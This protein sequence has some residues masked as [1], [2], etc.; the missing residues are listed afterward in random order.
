[1]IALLPASLLLLLGLPARA[2]EINAQRFSP[3]VDG[4]TFLVLN[5]PDVGLSGIGGGV[6]FNYAD[7]PFVFR[8]ADEELADIGLLDNIATANLTTFASL[9]NLSFGLDM[10]LHLASSGYGVD[11]FRLLGDLGLDGKLELL[12]RQTQGVGVGLRTRLGLPT[13]NGNAWLGDPHASVTG[14]VL[15]S[16]G[17]RVVLAVNAGFRGYMGRPVELPEVSWGNRALYGA[18]LSVPL[19]DNVWMT[20]ELTGE[21][22]F[23]SGTAS[24]AFP[25]EGLVTARGNPTEDLIATL[26]MGAGLT[27]GIGSPDFRFVAGLSWVPGLRPEPIQTVALSGPADAGLGPDADQDGVPDARDLCPDQAEDLNGKAD[28]D[29]CPDGGLVPT[30]IEVRDERGAQVAGAEIEL[31]AGP[32]VGHWKLQDGELVR[33]L[34]PGTYQIQAR[35]E[36]YTVDEGRLTIPDVPRHAVTLRIARVPEKGTLTLTVMDEKGQPVA[37]RARLIGAEQEIETASDGVGQDKV[38]AGTWEVIVSAPGYNVARR[39]LT[40]EPDGT[41][42]VDVLLQTTRVQVTDDRIIILDKVFFEF[43]SAVIKPESFGL[44]DEV[45]ATLQEHAEIQQ[46]EVQ[47]HSDDQGPDDYNLKLSQRRA[48]AVREYLVRGGV[49]AGRLTARGYGE[50]QPLQEGQTLEARAA[51]RRVEFLIRQRAAASR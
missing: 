12:D 29:G 23:G 38:P 9:E 34:P 25:L 44:L 14:E 27:R 17:D 39:T 46:V 43:D 37:A 5:D 4:R 35:A 24:G 47:G 6:T 49:A 21:V 32:E 16:A 36:G 1:M 2:Q 15:A 8:F 13:G 10:P 22:I 48:E 30:L 40:V 3:S 50:L 7:D 18:G 28:D 11:G 31:L 42:S 26:G 51:N 20:G 19:R 45:V 41:S 33:S